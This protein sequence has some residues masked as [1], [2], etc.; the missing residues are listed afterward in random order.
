[1]PRQTDLLG[2]FLP[3]FLPF[4]LQSIGRKIVLKKCGTRK[5]NTDKIYQVYY[6]TQ[7]KRR[8]SIHKNEC[9]RITNNTQ[10]CAYLAIDTLHGLRLNNAG[11]KHALGVFTPT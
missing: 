8:Q 2:T 5:N 7:N 3:Q 1:M 10:A 9:K 11:A 4:I 6:T